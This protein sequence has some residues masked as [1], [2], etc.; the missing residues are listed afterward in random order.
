MYGDDLRVTI[1]ESNNHF[2]VTW[3][4]MKLLSVYMFMTIDEKQRIPLVS[5]YGDSIF[6]SGRLG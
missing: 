4:Q 6:R 3:P 2:R 1:S 5:K